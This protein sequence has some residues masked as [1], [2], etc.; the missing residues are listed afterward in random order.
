MELNEYQEKAMTT[1][2]ES[3]NN[4]SYMALNLIG[5]LG[6]LMGK[7]A[8]RIRKDEAKIVNNHIILNNDIDLQME[9][10]DAFWQFAG[11]CK[12]MGWKLEDI[13]QLNLDKLANRKERNVIIGEGDDR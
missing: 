4:F 10:G 13:A 9:A 1:C 5:E 8:K 2:T 12:V 7:I 11:L 3:S 6:E